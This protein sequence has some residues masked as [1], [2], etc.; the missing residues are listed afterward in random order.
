MNASSVTPNTAGIESSAKS[1]AVV[2][3]ARNPAEVGPKTGPKTA[4]TQ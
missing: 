4:E 1:R 3:I 2:E